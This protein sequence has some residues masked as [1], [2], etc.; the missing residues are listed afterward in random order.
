MEAVHYRNPSEA[1]CLPP[2]SEITSDAFAL[3]LLSP[4]PG[5]LPPPL[6]PSYR[7]PFGGH[8]DQSSSTNR[9]PE[10]L[11]VRRPVGDFGGYPCALNPTRQLP[12][13][14]VTTELASLIRAVRDFFDELY[15]EQSL[16]NDN[17][18]EEAI[19]NTEFVIK[20]LRDCRHSSGKPFNEANRRRRRC[21]NCGVIEIDTP[22]WRRGP[23]GSNT[24]CNACGRSYAKRKL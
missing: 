16:P 5:D 1:S 20:Q 2:I 4:Q 3:P 17:L 8:P 24:L 18:L 15:H 9:A 7:P 19:A 23:N 10:G 12:S 6:A 22:E 13:G 14:P 11:S 21:H